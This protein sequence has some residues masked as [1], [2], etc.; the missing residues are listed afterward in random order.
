MPAA[1]AG[2][3]NL[4]NADL[5]PALLRCVH[6]FQGP[7]FALQGGHVEVVKHEAVDAAAG[8][9]LHDFAV[10]EEID[11]GLPLKGAAGN[12]GLDIIALDGKRSAGEL[13]GAFIAVLGKVTVD[14]VPALAADL[15]ESCLDPVPIKRTRPECGAFHGPAGEGGLGPILENDVGTQWGRIPLPGPSQSGSVRRCRRESLNRCREG[16]GCGAWLRQLPPVPATSA[17]SRTIWFLW[18]ARAPKLFFK[19][20]AFC[21]PP[22]SDAVMEESDVSFSVKL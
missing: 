19:H 13:A 14:H 9:A 6:D 7:L 22:A 8:L 12:P 2:E 4:A 1:I 5:A 18:D 11:A 17:P 3:G 20:T 10:D 21:S 16:S 15:A